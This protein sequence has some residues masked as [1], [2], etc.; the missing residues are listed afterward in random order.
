MYFIDGK[1]MIDDVMPQ[2]PAEKAGL[3][4]GDIL[5]GS[6]MICAGIYTLAFAFFWPQKLG[7]SPRMPMWLF[8]LLAVG[9]I[10]CGLIIIIL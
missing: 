2:S 7:L 4:K 10:L 5:V 9:M 3:M 6:I 8:R 1:I